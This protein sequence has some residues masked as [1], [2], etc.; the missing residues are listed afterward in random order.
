MKHLK[1]V[2]NTLFGLLLLLFSGAYTPVY[3]QESTVEDILPD[4]MDSVEISLLTC[5][6]HDEI[7][8]LYGHTA[9]RYHDI[10]KG[11]EV[12][13][14]FNYGVFDF[15]KPYFVL[16]FVFGLTDYELG[17]YPFSLF[18][19]EYRHFGSMVTEQ[20]LNLTSEEKLLLHEALRQ[21]LQP[22][23]SVYRYN[24]FYNNCTT[25]A[26]D[27]IEKCITGK[28]EYAERENFTPTYREMVHEMTRNHPWARFGND[29]LL[30]IK[31]DQPTTLRQQEF[32][33]YNLMYDFDHAQIYENGQYRPLVKERRTAL[34]GGVQ[35]VKQGFPL[36]PIACAILLTVTGLILLILQWRSK[37]SFLFWDILLMLTI[38][39]IGIMLTLMLFSQH[40]TVSL[41]L[42]ILLF[43]PL[44][45]FFLWPVIKGRQNRYWLVS[46]VLIALFFIGSLFQQYAEG[47]WSLALC[48][49]MQCYIHIKKVS[50]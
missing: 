47:L 44:P 32:L 42:Q 12:D 23:N 19:K 14:A 15:K 31:A 33:P 17:V 41:N 11:K 40:P 36:S 6:P 5:Q 13:V 22:G 50:R 21:N 2:F 28:T 49:L 1:T 20:V 48:L 38:G 3:A 45:W 29:L 39:T 34:P 10:R 35:I 7:Y 16:R 4:P 43:N 9:I 46:C 26:R 27:I 18:L 24:Y 25:K 37:R 30:G 8:S